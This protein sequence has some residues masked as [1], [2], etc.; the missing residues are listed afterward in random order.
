M[1]SNL[2]ALC[3]LPFTVLLTQPYSVIP[4]TMFT[5]PVPIIFLEELQGNFNLVLVGV[6]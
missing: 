2:Q 5:F 3:V 4:C 1:V 6:S